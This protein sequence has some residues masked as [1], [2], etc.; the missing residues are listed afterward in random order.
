LITMKKYLFLSLI[1]LMLGA[2]ELLA[3]RYSTAVGVRAGY[4]MGFSYKSYVKP[5]VAFEGILAVRWRGV[6][7]TALVQKHHKLLGVPGVQWYYG[8][9]MHAGYWNDVETRQAL[10]SGESSVILGLD[11]VVG[12]EYTFDE[13]PINVS[14][15]WIPMVNIIGGRV[16]GNVAGGG[17]LAIRYAF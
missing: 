13:I 4:G 6:G 1:F 11:G 5:K 10:F 8:G 14:L 7:A 2:T 17:G 12:I 9:G 16:A 3:Q 15:D